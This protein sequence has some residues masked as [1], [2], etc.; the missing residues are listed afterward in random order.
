MKHIFA[1][2]F[3]F[4]GIIK[5]LRAQSVGDPVSF[6]KRKNV[7]QILGIDYPN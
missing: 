2:A 7:V 4:L 6:I 5:N 3:F 1:I